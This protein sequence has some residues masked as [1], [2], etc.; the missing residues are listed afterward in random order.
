VREVG[1]LGDQFDALGD[2]GAGR[3]LLAQGVGD[4]VDGLADADGRFVHFDDG[5]VHF[6][7]SSGAV[8]GAPLARLIMAKASS[9]LW[10]MPLT[11]LE[12]CR[13]T[14]GRSASLRTSSATTA[15]PPLFAGA[16]RLDGGV[17]GQQV[18]LVGNFADHLDDAGDV[19]DLGRSSSMVVA[20]SDMPAA[21]LQ[22]D[23]RSPGRPP[24]G[25]CG[26]GFPMLRRSPASLALCDMAPMLTVSS[27]T[28]AAMAEVDALWSSAVWARR[29]ASRAWLRSR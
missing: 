1:A 25:W 28:A 24:A 5:V 7:G 20:A 27:S 14:G 19:A 21:T 13:W 23:V 22:D 17:E 26:P 29:A 6:G 9:V 3:G 12:I 16:G 8:E 15:K 11:M 2:V 4:A 10:R 18:G